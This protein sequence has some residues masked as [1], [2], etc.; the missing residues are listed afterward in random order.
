MGYTAGSR[1][2]PSMRSSLGRKRS[3]RSKRRAR[4]AMADRV[5]WMVDAGSLRL[6]DWVLLMAASSH[7][8]SRRRRD[9]DPPV[10]WTP[11]MAR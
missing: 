2:S 6:G 10:S 7:V 5:G 1:W 3:M 4:D 11:Q 8:A 9:E